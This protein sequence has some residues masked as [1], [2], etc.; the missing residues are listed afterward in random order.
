MFG[1]LSDEDSGNDTGNCGK[2]GGQSSEAEAES[3][4]VRLYLDHVQQAH[5]GADMDFL[6]GCRGSVVKR[7]SH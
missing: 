6:V 7:D 1:K 3:G 2:P 4:Y 5:Q